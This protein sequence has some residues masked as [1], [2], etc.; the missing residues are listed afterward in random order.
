L[1][2]AHHEYLSDVERKHYAESH[3]DFERSQIIE[4]AI[5]KK[6]CNG[7]LF[8]LQTLPFFVPQNVKQVIRKA[9]TVEPSAR[10]NNASAFMNAL[11]RLA[12]RVIDWRYDEEKSLVAIH[13]TTRYRVKCDNRRYSAEQNK[14]R[15]WRRIP[16]T[17]T[18]TLKE[19]LKIIA[20]RA[21]RK[22]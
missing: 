13:G 5:M 11:T 9:T 6:A 4:T 12:Y 18:G 10:Y 8:D 19:Q 20:R 16:G 21:L 2:Y 14:G 17:K 15:G 1:P 3:D 7:T 22:H